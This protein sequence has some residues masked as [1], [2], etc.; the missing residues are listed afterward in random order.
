MLYENM[1]SNAGA[2]PP[3]DWAAMA[4]ISVFHT[5]AVPLFQR[6]SIVSSRFPRRRMQPESVSLGN[7]MFGGAAIFQRVHEVFGLKAIVIS[8]VLR[9]NPR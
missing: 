9:G 3:K 4:R 5:T 1:I 7:V 6:W 8:Y 2:I